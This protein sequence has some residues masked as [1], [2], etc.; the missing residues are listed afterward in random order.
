M[1]RPVR[2]VAHSGVTSVPSAADSQAKRAPA[3]PRSA[4]RRRA[5]SSRRMRYSTIAL[6]AAGWTAA[7]AGSTNTSA[8]QKTCPA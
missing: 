3:S 5:G 1:G 7:R 2:S 4:A 8:S 6:A